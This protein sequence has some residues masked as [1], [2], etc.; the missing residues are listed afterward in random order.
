MFDLSENKCRTVR[1]PTMRRRGRDALFRRPR[2][3]L[4][5][6]VTVAAHRRWRAKSLSG[7]ASGAPQR[8]WLIEDVTD[9]SSLEVSPRAEKNHREHRDGMRGPAPSTQY[10][11]G[12]QRAHGP[13]K[14]TDP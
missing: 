3:N 4:R 9:E 6:D 11:D 10:L 14:R 8:P 12:L 2:E 7:P 1:L 13:R 5:F